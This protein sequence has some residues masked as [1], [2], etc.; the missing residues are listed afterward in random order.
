MDKETKQAKPTY[1]TGYD[2]HVWDFV[3]SRKTWSGGTV[4]SVALTKAAEQISFSP[5]FEVFTIRIDFILH[6]MAEDSLR[7]MD[8]EHDQRWS[9]PLSVAGSGNGWVQKFAAE[10]AER[11]QKQVSS[12]LTK[13][14]F[15]LHPIPIPNTFQMQVFDMVAHLYPSLFSID[16]TGENKPG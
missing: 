1:L 7:L 8:L 13:T 9:I 15:A 14:P 6:I 4:L 2:T 11:Y 10:V 16:R 3:E 12:S 5:E